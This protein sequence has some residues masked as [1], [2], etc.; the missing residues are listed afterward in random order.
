MNTT[1]CTY[2]NDGGT[3]PTIIASSCSTTGT[4][5]IETPPLTVDFTT[6]HFTLS[7]FLALA[8]FWV[9]FHI[10]NKKNS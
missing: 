3:P 10:T 9:F 7:L 2:T 4:T 8:T 1:N 6:L 5:T